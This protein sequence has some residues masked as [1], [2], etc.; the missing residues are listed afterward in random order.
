[1]AIVTITVSDTDDGEVK[2]AAVFDPPVTKDDLGTPAQHTAMAMV[3][4]A[5][6][7][8]DDC[9]AFDE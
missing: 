7:G 6:G 8:A 9:E 4:I 3:Q 2:L 1:M 5:T